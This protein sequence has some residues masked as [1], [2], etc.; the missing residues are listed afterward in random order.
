MK[1]E[2][3]RIE[4]YVADSDDAQML[5]KLAQQSAGE[6][7]SFTR[8]DFS[9]S[10]Q[11]LQKFS[12]PV[13]VKAPWLYTFEFSADAVRALELLCDSR[14]EHFKYLECR[15]KELNTMH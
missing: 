14:L 15:A 3:I 4:F 2:H 11:L 1:P 9:L 10:W 6:K 8:G 7:V 5:S 12:F 13:R